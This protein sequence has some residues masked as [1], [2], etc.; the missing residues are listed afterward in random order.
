[1]NEKIIEDRAEKMMDSVD[2]KYL[3]GDLTLEEYNK[4][5][6]IITAWIDAKYNE[7]FSE[8]SE[9]RLTWRRHRTRP[10]VPGS[11]SGIIGPQAVMSDRLLISCSMPSSRGKR[12][13]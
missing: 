5:N 1:M 9:G 3:S 10:M 4:Q 2:R 6:D 12:P 7:I 8:K 13:V 11:M